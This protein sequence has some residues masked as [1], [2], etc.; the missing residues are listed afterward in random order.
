MKRERKEKT[1]GKK[2]VK[3]GIVFKMLIGILVPLFAVL[4]IISIFLGL[5]GSA[6]V[7]EVMSAELD[8][9]ARSAASQV[10]DF[11]DKY[12][13]AAE[14]LAATQ[15]VQDIVSVETEGGITANSQY[16]SMLETLRQIQ[17]DNAEDIDYVWVANLKTGELL[18]SDG[19]LFGAG[20]IEFTT[21]SWY[22]LVMDKQESITTEVYTSANGDTDMVTIA[23]PVFVNGQIT[24]VIGM[25]LDMGYLRQTLAGVTVGT[26][27]YITLYD[28]NDQIIY[29]P[30][31]SVTG[32]NAEDANYSSNM[33]NAIVNKEDSDAMRYTRNGT[34][35][36][37]STA[38]A[39]V[40]DFVVLGVMPVSEYTSHTSAILRIVL[41]GMISCAV[42]LTALCIF[43][44][45]SIT[46]PLK[47][48]D[49]AVGKLAD[50]ELDVVVDVRGRD[51]VSELGANVVR[52]VE[53]LKEYILY[54]DEISRVL[55]QIGAGNLVFT[56]EHEYTGEFS[57]VKEALLHIRS[58]LTETLTTI[59]QSADQ[60]NAGSEQIASGAQALAQGATEQAS[61][62]Q[63]LSSA[64][65]EL[66]GQ[67]TEESKKA[68]KAE[69]FLEQIRDEVEK[70]NEK[71]EQMRT[72]M[73]DISVQ[74]TAIRGI[75]KTIDD[76]AFQTNIL[77]L[78]AAVEAARAGSAGKGF[79]VVADEVRNLAG[80]SAEAAK[81][82]NKLIENSV[83]AVQHGE[84]LTNLT[85]DSLEIVADGTKQVVETIEAVA[86][87][88]QEQAN[89]ISEIAK[90][91]E[92]IS[93]VVQTN[94]ATAEESAA[95]SEELSGQVGMMRHQVAQF[96]LGEDVAEPI[97][98][99]EPAQTTFDSLSGGGKY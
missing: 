41:I 52:I 99:L 65:Q 73:E 86:L 50:G 69:K 54:I 27:G 20:Q 76:I 35:Y 87:A 28:L 45:L 75:I 82:T 57:K 34:E 78:N 53:R 22:T 11:F 42:L 8:A 60:V 92:Q 39:D 31:S 5:Q 25:D 72:A 88:Y 44:A 13:G 15:I 36:Y 51:E 29:H 43:I 70:S 62:V 90:G 71:M 81:K 46:R 10:N 21:R 77:A 47:R 84:E 91:V 30:D 3:F 68:L 38:I 33:L 97:H 24:G 80:K 95:A 61:S 98:R 1:T 59:A 18:Q 49:V 2:R 94:S 67:V 16:G 55:R 26:S 56:L 79:A 17:Q 32:T 37:G 63:E 85:A 4:I 14:S 9:E 74:S 40:P 7:N 83:Q 12:Y 89:R 93:S 19:T 58:T 64:I 96:K 23:S 48:L 66:S 6:T